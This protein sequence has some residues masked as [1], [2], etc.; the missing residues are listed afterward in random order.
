MVAAWMMFADRFLPSLPCDDF[1]I[2]S[3]WMQGSVQSLALERNLR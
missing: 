1:L 2:R 3:G